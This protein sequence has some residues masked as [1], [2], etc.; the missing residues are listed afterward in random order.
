MKLISKTIKSLSIVLTAIVVLIPISNAGED[1]GIAT[2]RYNESPANVS[3]FKLGTD[4]LLKNGGNDSKLYTYTDNGVV[5]V[6][7]LG[8]AILCG[9]NGCNSNGGSTLSIGKSK[10]IS[11]TYS[12]TLG[13]SIGLN[14]VTDI[15][16]GVGASKTITYC[17][18]RNVAVGCSVSSGE[19][20][21]SALT[22]VVGMRLQKQT[23][24]MTG[25]PKFLTSPSKKFSQKTAFCN[26]ANGAYGYNYDYNSCG[27]W[28]KADYIVYD[29]F[30]TGLVGNCVVRPSNEAAISKNQVLP[31]SY[32]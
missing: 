31:F 29:R 9:S 2:I 8:A 16:G 18:S 12:F 19:H 10:C 14:E 4:W 20:K 27:P 1:N 23:R 15:N 30:P 7:E 24:R 13:G 3:D 22:P 5:K 26:K 32:F 6:H 25:S 17:A 11:E 28:A 21:N